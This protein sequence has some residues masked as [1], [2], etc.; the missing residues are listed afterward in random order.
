MVRRLLVLL[1]FL[2]MRIA[3]EQRTGSH[4]CYSSSMGT[5]DYTSI[6]VPCR[7][8]T[9]LFATGEPFSWLVFAGLG[10][11]WPGLAFDLCV[12]VPVYK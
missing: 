7:I 12:C 10:W 4:D 2:L 5:G 3:E 11:T 8:G 1:E 9:M 6:S